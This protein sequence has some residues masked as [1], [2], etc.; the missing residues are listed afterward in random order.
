V[1]LQTRTILK[2]ALPAAALLMVVSLNILVSGLPSPGLIVGVVEDWSTHHVVYTNPGTATEALAQGRFVEWYRLVNQPR[3][4]M[5]QLRRDPLLRATVTAPDFAARAALLRGSMEASDALMVARK[6]P[7]PTLKKDWNFDVGPIG[8]GAGNFPAKFSF[9]GGVSSSDI[10]VFNTSEAGSTTSATVIGLNNLYT[11]SPNVAFAYN[12]T[13][14]DTVATSVAFDLTGDQIAFISTNGGH[15]YLNV[16]RFET[17]SGNGTAYAT[18]VTLTASTTAS[19]FTTCKQGSGAC[20]YRLEFANAATDTNSS[21]YYDYSSDRLWVGDNSGNVH[22]FTGVFNGSVAESGNPW[23]TTGAATVLTSPVYDGSTYVYVGAANGSVYTFT[24]STGAKYATSASLTGS[25]GLGLSDSALLDVANNMLYESVGYDAHGDSGVTQV[26]TPGLGTIS[27][28]YFGPGSTTIP[29]YTGTFD[30]SHY[31]SGGTTGVITTCNWYTDLYFNPIALAGFSS[32][33][34]IEYSSLS[35]DHYTE[36]TTATV[37]CSPQ[38][39]I[40]NGSDDYVF[41]SVATSANQAV[42]NCATGA[43]GCVYG[44][45]VGNATTY[46]WDTTSGVGT[47]PAPN[48][49]FEIQPNTG[50]QS[51][52]SAII[53]DNTASGGSNI[54]FTTNATTNG[55]PCTNTAHGCAIQVSQSAL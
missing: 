41:M 29:L 51:S 46:N 50:G 10:A 14:G 16:L 27:E 54:Y 40:L 34:R 4:I 19:A 24:A 32:G 38:T 39:E 6:R 44:F 11:T 12:T 43:H 17:S 1:K 49:G 33:N 8:V 5:Q 3:Y 22:E 13:T 2:L 21:P 18:P 45:I 23:G 35:T 25:T 7:H 20:L 30:N 42:G 48:E 28:V 55:A 26:V 9:I 36:L 53:I 31:L 37:A 52:T 15:A 47:G